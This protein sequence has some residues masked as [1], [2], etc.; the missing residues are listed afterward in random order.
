MDEMPRL[1]GSPFTDVGGNPQRSGQRCSSRTTEI[2]KISGI[3]AI[4]H[5]KDTG[6][7]TGKS[8]DS[9]VDVPPFLARRLRRFHGILQNAVA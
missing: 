6:Q 5:P 8:P 4:P 3:A 2:Q 7:L 9:S 1:A